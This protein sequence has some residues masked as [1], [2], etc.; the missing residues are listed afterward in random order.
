MTSAMQNVHAVE[1]Q[2]S[3]ATAR[4]LIMSIAVNLLGT[5]T[6]L[7]SCAGVIL[8]IMA[9]VTPISPGEWGGVEKLFFLLAAIPAIVL[10]LWMLTCLWGI[11]RGILFFAFVAAL[12]PL[13]AAFDYAGVV[14]LWGSLFDYAGVDSVWISRACLA[15]ATALLVLLN[16][17]ESRKYMARRRDALARSGDFSGRLWIT[18]CLTIGLPSMFL[19][20]IVIEEHMEMRRDAEH[21]DQTERENAARELTKQAEEFVARGE[22]EKAVAVYEDIDRR[23]RKDADPLIQALV[24]EAAY[25]KNVILGEPKIDERFCKA[26]KDVRRAMGRHFLSRC[27]GLFYDKR[28]DD[29]AALLAETLKCVGDDGEAMEDLAWTRFHYGEA[30]EKSGRLDEAYR[31]YDDADRLFW[32]EGGRKPIVI[33]NSIVGK[34][35][36]R[37]KQDKPDQ[38]ASIF[39][40][41][42]QRTNAGGDLEHL[43]H[44]TLKIMFE[45]GAAFHGQNDTE[46]ALFVFDQLIDHFGEPGGSSV[47]SDVVRSLVIKGHILRE[48]R[49]FAKALL[50]Y[51]EVENSYGSAYVDELLR[52][53]A[54]IGKGAALGQLNRLEDELSAYEKA[55]ALLE[56][57][58]SFS[59]DGRIMQVKIF[60]LAPLLMLGRIDAIDQRI[61][62]VQRYEEGRSFMLFV[63]WLAD[64]RR[65]LDPVLGAIEDRG[66]HFPRVDSSYLNGEPVMDWPVARFH[67]FVDKLVGPRKAQGKCLL[68]YFDKKET[69]EELD[70]CLKHGDEH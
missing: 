62:T 5:M 24:A 58:N 42:R 40:E 52:A 22:H 47:F 56:K 10:A 60:S 14:S 19:T 39:R 59:G 3:S 57:V 23:F 38:A 46:K 2:Q 17:P 51:D 44:M 64:A 45:R 29:G 34:A 13:V 20:N 33:I 63:S 43:D 50:A 32:K 12:P 16:L 8:L 25:G 21:K 4:P 67:P 27:N 68:D 70:A 26:G 41:L 11:L 28:I 54:L 48:R 7:L 65:P 35:L 53:D 49:L 9:F 30:L 31:V 37:V 69:T 15:Y 55:L 1:E 61:K 66:A 6:V 36:V 18:A